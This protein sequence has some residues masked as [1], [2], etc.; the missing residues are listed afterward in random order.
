M[1]VTGQEKA[2]LYLFDDE[3]QLQAVKMALFLAQVQCRIV[4]KEEYGVPLKILAADEEGSSA[5]AYGAKEL[6]GQMVVFAGLGQDKLESAL[7]LLRSN[8]A[9]GKIP[10]KA[11]LTQT[12]QNW[13]GFTLFEELQKEH[14]A[15]QAAG[16]TAQP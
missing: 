9:C 1:C 5:A 13:N 8:P 14:A 3:A 7:S 2:L 6:E 4:S 12:N 11:V 10:Y 15:M 16:K